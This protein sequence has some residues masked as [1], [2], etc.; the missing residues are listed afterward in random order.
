MQVTLLVII[1]K[2]WVMII[3]LDVLKMALWPFLKWLN[4]TMATI[5]V[6]WAMT[7]EQDWAKSSYWKSMVSKSLL[8]KAYYRKWVG[9][10]FNGPKVT[11]IVIRGTW[12]QVLIAEVIECHKWRP[13]IHS[14][15]PQCYL[16]EINRIRFY[17]C[18][19]YVLYL[20]YVFTVLFWLRY[21]TKWYK[22]VK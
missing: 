10:T 3:E 16:Y 6:K 19:N 20:C 22:R 5:C 18:P 14:N 7:A 2:L 13:A 11:S 8:L 12:L 15:C 9:K 4:L 1:K 17:S 21:L